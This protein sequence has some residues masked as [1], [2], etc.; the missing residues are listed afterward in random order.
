MTK[1]YTHITPEERFLIEKMLREKKSLSYIAKLINRSKS[2]ISYEVRRN[3]GI[4]RYKHVRATDR[5]T[6]KQRLKKRKQ[7]AVVAD[8]VLR[9]R[10]DRMI[11]KG[12]S[13]EA[14]SRK[15]SEHKKS[16]SVSSKSIRKYRFYYYKP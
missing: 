16:V 9:K 2:S 13:P 14:I 4:G 1:K 15:I 6:V 10:V 7:N 11:V 12:M 8:P 3:R 5:Y